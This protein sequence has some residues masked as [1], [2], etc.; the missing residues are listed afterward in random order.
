MAIGHF[1]SSYA[2]PNIIN[3]ILGTLPSWILNCLKIIPLQ[4]PR[5]KFSNLI[6][7]THTIGDYNQSMLRFILWFLKDPL[8]GNLV[9]NVQSKA[10][11]SSTEWW[12]SGLRCI[13]IVTKVS[14][15]DTVLCK[16][17]FVIRFTVLSILNA[18]I[19]IISTTYY[20]IFQWSW[21]ILKTLACYTYWSLK[22]RYWQDL[23]TFEG[24]SDEFFFFW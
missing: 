8:K 13:I 24:F 16:A 11:S 19:H 9:W 15:T 23:D 20:L 14:A 2:I 17:F 12:W 21:N 10:E 22:S 6:S 18:H 3:V 7:N 4:I 5:Q 1:D